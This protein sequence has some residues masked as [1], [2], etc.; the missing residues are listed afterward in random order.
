MITGG[1]FG[2]LAIITISVCIVF[3]VIVNA[4]F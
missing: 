3:T 1:E 4:F 2:C